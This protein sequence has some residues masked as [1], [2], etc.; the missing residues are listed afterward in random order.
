[1]VFLYVKV[2]RLPLQVFTIDMEIIV[3]LL[4]LRCDDSARII[5]PFNP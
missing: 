5:A 2:I 3:I 4:S 1:M